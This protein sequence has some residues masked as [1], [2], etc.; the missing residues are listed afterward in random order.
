MPMYLPLWV[1]FPLITHHDFYCY[2]KIIK[3][4][5]YEINVYDEIVLLLSKSTNLNL[6]AVI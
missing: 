6:N 5:N 4:R 3:N 2:I 1:F